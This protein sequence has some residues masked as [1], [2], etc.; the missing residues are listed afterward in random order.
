MK[1]SDARAMVDEARHQELSGIKI[2]IERAI[3]SAANRGLYSTMVVVRHELV[4]YITKY[5]R[6][7]DFVVTTNEIEGDAYTIEIRWKI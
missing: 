4:E 7:R 2:N 6:E 5:F 1:A 3:A